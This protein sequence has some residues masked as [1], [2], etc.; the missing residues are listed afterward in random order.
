MACSCL[1]KSHI[2]FQIIQG[3][4]TEGND[5]YCPHSKTST[6]FF[7]IFFFFFL[8]LSRRKKNQKCFSP[9]SI[10]ALASIRKS[11]RDAVRSAFTGVV[12]NSS[13]PPSNPR[14]MPVCCRR[15]PDPVPRW[16][17]VYVSGDSSCWIS[18]ILIRS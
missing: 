9:S 3:V 11:R 12:R 6:A 13:A 18:G 17:D 14:P 1:P 16:C 5:L 7:F 10:C 15:E 4:S 8:N 2:I